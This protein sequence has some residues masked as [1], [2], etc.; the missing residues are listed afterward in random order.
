METP[1]AWL[2]LLREPKA[3]RAPLPP[4]LRAI[5][6]E[7]FH[8]IFFGRRGRHWRTILRKVGGFVDE[9]DSSTYA[10]IISAN[11]HAMSVTNK[12]PGSMGFR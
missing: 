5:M 1:D 3:A 7:Q 10:A 2:G 9:I 12:Y 11:T 4:T 8:R 6:I